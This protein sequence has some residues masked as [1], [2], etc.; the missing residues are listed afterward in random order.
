MLDEVTEDVD[1]GKSLRTEQLVLSNKS[2]GADYTAAALAFGL[3][4]T[5]FFFG[6]V[7]YRLGAFSFSIA[8]AL[9]A[10]PVGVL[11]A[12]WLLLVDTRRRNDLLRIDGGDGLEKTRDAFTRLADDLQW[13]KNRNNAR[14]ARYFVER[15]VVTALFQPDHIFVNCRRTDRNKLRMPISKRERDELM[16][17]VIEGMDTARR[18]SDSA[19]SSPRG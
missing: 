2:L 14:Y 9:L 4:P 12:G 13:T 11:W 1:V 16:R 18:T 3:A 6:L 10:I 5:S 7:L 8:M 17:V 15:Y 19:S